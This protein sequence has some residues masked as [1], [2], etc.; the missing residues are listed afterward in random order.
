MQVKETGFYHLR[1]NSYNH[2]QRFNT[3]WFLEKVLH[4]WFSEEFLITLN[5]RFISEYKRI[6]IYDVQLLNNYSQYIQYSVQTQTQRNIDCRYM[7]HKKMDNLTSIELGKESTYFVK[8]DSKLS[9]QCTKEV[10]VKMLTS[11]IDNIFGQCGRHFLLYT[12]ANAL[13]FHNVNFSFICVNDPFYNSNVIPDL[14]I[15]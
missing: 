12:V 14:H 8:T 10:V 1:M 3:L 7:Y 13:S 15:T 6:K 4:I 11:F 9:F 5:G 2:A